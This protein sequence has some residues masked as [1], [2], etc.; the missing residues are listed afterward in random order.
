L[1]LPCLW[2]LAA[3][4]AIFEQRLLAQAPRPRRSTM[5]KPLAAL[6]ALAAVGP[7]ALTFSSPFASR[8]DGELPKSR[9]ATSISLQSLCEFAD[10]G[11]STPQ[12][13]LVFSGTTGLQADL[14]GPSVRDVDSDVSMHMLMPKNIRWKKPQ[15]PTVRSFRGDEC[16]IQH[17]KYRGLAQTGNKHQFGKWALQAVDELW[18]SNRAIEQIRRTL[19]RGMER[20]GK[21]WIRCFPHSGVTKRNLETR[22]GGGKGGIDKWVQAV[23]PGFILFE[24]DGVKD[25]VAHEIFRKVQFRIGGMCRTIKKVDGPSKWDLGLAGEEKKVRRETKKPEEGGKGKK[26]KK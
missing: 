5:K 22:M 2:A 9:T 21:I 11:S 13:K 6:C 20:R 18:I 1:A 26:E 25:N 8:M 3:A 15:R 12:A 10:A 7:L 24:I 16:G 23:R 17:W 19:V 14:R 4:M